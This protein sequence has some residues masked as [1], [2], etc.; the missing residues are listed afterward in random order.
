MKSLTKKWLRER[1]RDPYYRRAKK[2]G[3]RSRAIYK[4][5][6]ISDKYHLIKTGD[7]V[8]DLGS[9]PGGWIQGARMLVGRKGYVVGIDLKPI[10]PFPWP[11]VKTLVG[12]IMQIDVANI[13][14]MLPRKAD[15]IISDVSPN[16]S[17][18]W[19]V[20][21]AKQ[22]DVAR[23]SFNLTNTLLRKGGNLL[24]KT[25]QGEF[26]KNLLEEVKERFS[27]VGIFKPKASKK[28][29]AEV[30]IVALKYDIFNRYTKQSIKRGK[31]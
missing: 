9:F 24:V 23:A 11:N 31:I 5:F 1:E 4:L 14:K 18:I 12:D 7:V 13:L 3:F 16:I 27:F 10:H 26:F 6:Q 2:E 22:I 20:D 8:I 25:F 30:Y 28:R 21:H 29:S 15:V 17:G 19:E